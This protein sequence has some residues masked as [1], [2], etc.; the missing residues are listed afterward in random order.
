M[1][2]IKEI[3]QSFLS[4]ASASIKMDYFGYGLK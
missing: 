1:K 4:K 2:D 3:E